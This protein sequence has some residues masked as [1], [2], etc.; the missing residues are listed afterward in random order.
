VALK[1]PPCVSE[2]VSDAKRGFLKAAM[3]GAGALDAAAPGVALAQARV[4]FASASDF[5][6]SGD[7]KLRHGRA[8]RQPDSAT[9]TRRV[10]TENC[11]AAIIDVQ[12]YFLSQ[13]GSRTARKQ[14]EAITLNFARMLGYF[15]IPIVATLERPIERTGSLP[16][17]L[18]KQLG[19]AAQ[20]EKNFFDLS[21][22][23]MI[24]DHLTRL[25]K[26]QVIIAG[27]ETDVCVLQSCLG[28]I[29]LGYEVFVVKD[30]VFSSAHN[31]D[32]ALAR[33]QIEGAVILT[34]KMLYYELLQGVGG[35]HGADDAVAAFRPSPVFVP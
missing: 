6:L 23:R 17:A 5:A 11:A 28:L 25:N 34:Y 30:L 15:R 1:T 31:V 26:K 4:G 8:P 12:D 7:S 10:I 21:K 32:A 9:L 33:M 35:G 3:L 18:E 13:I 27:C 22:E 19:E 20:F 24:R 16:A 2:N 29:D 14:M